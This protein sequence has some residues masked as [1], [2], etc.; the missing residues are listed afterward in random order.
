MIQ[1]QKL[2]CT[3]G[4]VDFLSHKIL[5]FLSNLLF[6]LYELC[7]IIYLMFLATPSNPKGSP[8]VHVIKTIN[9]QLVKS[10]EY[11]EYKLW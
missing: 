4:K 10:F 8:N 5:C 3:C 11:R 2:T 9:G 6:F 7:Y 1:Q